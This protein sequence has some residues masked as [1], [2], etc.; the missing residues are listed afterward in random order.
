MK[1]ARSKFISRLT[2]CLTVAG[3]LFL[4]H[5]PL[6]A[7]YDPSAPSFVSDLKDLEPGKGTWIMMTQPGE[8]SFTNP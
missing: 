1:H 8:L 5:Q 2:C 4:F 6:N 3:G 7:V